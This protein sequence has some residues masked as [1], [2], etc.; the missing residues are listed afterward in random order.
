MTKYFSFHVLE[1][2]KSSSPVVSFKYIL[3]VSYNYPFVLFYIRTSLP[4]IKLCF[5]TRSVTYSAPALSLVS[6]DLSSTPLCVISFLS[7]H[8]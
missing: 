6:S 3:A 1:N 2:D 8:T 7:F 4:P 5:V